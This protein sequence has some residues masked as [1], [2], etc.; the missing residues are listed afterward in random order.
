[1]S[2]EDLYDPLPEKEWQSDGSRIHSEGN[3]AFSTE[4]KWMMQLSNEKGVRKI[5]FN[6]EEFPDLAENDFAKEVIKIMHESS[7]L[8]D[9]IVQEAKAMIK[10][11]KMEGK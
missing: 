4:T 7:L 11:G 8:D 2:D 10:S 5:Y 3:I 6:T 9:L 1:M